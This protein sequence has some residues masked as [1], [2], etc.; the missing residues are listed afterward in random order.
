MNL[1]QFQ[2]VPLPVWYGLAVVM[3]GLAAWY[4]VKKTTGVVVDALDKGALDVTSE[5]NLA[6]RATNQAGRWFFGLD[7]NATIGTAI[8][9]LLHDEYDPNAPEP[10]KAPA[11]AKQ[12]V[13]GYDAA[14]AADLAVQANKGVPA[15]AGHSK[16]GN[17][18]YGYDVAKAKAAAQEAANSQI[19]KDVQRYGGG[20]GALTK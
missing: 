6:Y 7:K 17:V 12:P 19:A 13:L 11:K 4:A 10:S 3:G 8:Y 15:I 20:Y 16:K 9:D 14:K 18:W 1:S 5:N 2:R